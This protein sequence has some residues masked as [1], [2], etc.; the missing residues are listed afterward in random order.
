MCQRDAIDGISVQLF[1][2]GIETARNSER[3]AQ[4]ELNLLEKT[5]Y[6]QSRD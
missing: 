5:F 4:K 2:S 3:I 6:R 1:Y